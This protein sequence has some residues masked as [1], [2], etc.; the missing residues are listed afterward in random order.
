VCSLV[1]PLPE[2]SDLAQMGVTH[3]FAWFLSDEDIT[4]D[5]RNVTV[6]LT[7]EA[8]PGAATAFF[9]LGYIKASLRAATA[10]MEGCQE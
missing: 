9:A 2:D 5:F 7:H 10:E 1:S 8:G 3:A 6:P 4:V